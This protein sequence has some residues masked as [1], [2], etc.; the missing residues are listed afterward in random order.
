[1][2]KRLLALVLSVCML[3][4]MMPAAF[5]A[6]P[7]PA[8]T[9]LQW[10]TQETG[11]HY[12][13][14]F[15]WNRVENSANEYDVNLYGPDNTIIAETVWEFDATDTSPVLMAEMFREEPR[16]S[17]EYYFTVQALGDEQTWTASPVATSLKRTYTAPSAQLAIPTNVR[18]DGA[19]ACWDAV[20]DADE[21]YVKWYYADSASDEP[22]EIGASWGSNDTSKPLPSWAMTEHGEGYYTFAVRALSNYVDIIRPSELSPLS[23]NYATDGATTS[24]GDKL[25]D[26]LVNAAGAPPEDIKAAVKAL[27]QEELRVAMAADTSDDGVN[28]KIQALEKETGIDV[29]TSVQDGLGLDAEKISL[30]GAAL[31][32]AEG[33][34]KVNFQISK[35]E[36]DMVVEG[37]Y[38]NAVQFD[39]QMEG[40]EP[41]EEFA[42]PIKITMPLPQG[43]NPD[44]ARI[45]HYTAS[46]T[47]EEVVFPHIFKDKDGIY[48]ASFVVTHFSTFVFATATTAATI[49]DTYYDSLQEAIDA[50]ESGDTISLYSNHDDTEVRVA[51]KSLDINC[52]V[53]TLNPDVITLGA[54][55]T[56][57]VTGTSGEDQVIH[58]S[59]RSSSGGGSSSSGGSSSNRPDAS[60]SGAGGKVSASSNGT[61][62]ITPD[63]GYEISK[64]TVN[65]EEV[66]IPADGKLTGLDKDDKVVVTFAKITDEQPED[67]EPFA[68][69][70]AGAWY[71][72]A[73]QY[74]YENGMMN[75]TSSTRFSPDE[76]TT[77]AMIVTILHRLENE[78]AASSS[79]FTDVADGSY[80]ADAVAWS[81]ANG[82]VNGVSETS[83]APEDSIT[84]EQMAAILYRYAQFKGYD[85]SASNDLSG[86]TD[87]AQ[88][89]AYAVAA[90]QWANAEGLITGNTATTIDPTGNATR[91]EVATILM[92]FCENIAG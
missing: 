53:Y 12:P 48:Y 9:G 63:E 66:A 82:I 46:G 15:Q 44:K 76:T 27:D 86:Y 7:L 24:I 37:A 47:L 36:K 50:A 4:A 19:T 62:T 69:V 78:P 16:E 68:D 30:T 40:T 75:G 11:D 70:A 39:F 59:Y 6:E 84:R 58:I 74:V 71:A 83:F 51:G 42:V 34:D 90:M 18:W 61:V 64:I 45:L 38:A 2:K 26:I 22:Q 3:A 80:Y 14:D 5:A 31:N 57:T 79:D 23:D 92:R 29:N 49:G 33:T 60:V 56:K 89:S 73:V 77:R 20:P 72:D 91:A 35:P 67:N 88:I 10:I 87:A 13:W 85:I 52:G 65:G 21:Y 17:G 8:P 43:V 81:A 54:N 41:T 1:M 28:S 55:C 32:A 25:D